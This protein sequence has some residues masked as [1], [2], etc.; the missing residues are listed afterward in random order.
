MNGGFT[1]AY[2]GRNLGERFAVPPEIH[3]S[4]HIKFLR[5]PQSNTAPLGLREPGDHSH[6]DERRLK[7]TK[8]AKNLEQ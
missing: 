5:A 2:D 4:L 3:D 1:C 7:L 8:T 6:F